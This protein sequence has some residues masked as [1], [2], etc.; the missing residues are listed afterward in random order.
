MRGFDA[1]HTR[2]TPL[3]G[4]N[5]DDIPLIVALETSFKEP[6]ELVRH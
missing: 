6:F 5:D 2:E 3:H 1:C 4:P